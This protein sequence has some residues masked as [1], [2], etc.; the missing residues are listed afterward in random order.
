MFSNQPVG[1]APYTFNVQS[2]SLPPGLSMSPSGQLSGTPSTL[3]NYSFSL[4]ALDS[5]GGL[6]P[7]AG[8]QNFSVQV[9]A[10]SAPVAGASSVTVA[11]NSTA[12]PI[13]LNLSGGGPT[14][15]LALLPRMWPMRS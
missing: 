7:Y 13:T 8:A 3:G 12:N 15:C 11:A 2:G 1:T 4:R 6:G 5:S 10:G 14:S 9:N